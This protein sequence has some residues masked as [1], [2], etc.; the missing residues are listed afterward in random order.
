MSLSE[1]F[2]QNMNLLSDKGCLL[3]WDKDDSETKEKFVKYLQRQGFKGV[4]HGYTG[5]PW[6]FINLKNKVFACGRAG[7]QFTPVLFDCKF[8]ITD[9]KKIYKM[10]EKSPKLG[11]KKSID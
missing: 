3:V 6:W 10:Y 5:C 2:H 11:E 7:I 9:F 1:K 4:I 8:S